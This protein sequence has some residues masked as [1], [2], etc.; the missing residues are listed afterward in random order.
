MKKLLSTLTVIALFAATA[1]TF[2]QP[3]RRPDEKPGFQPQGGP[4]QPGVKPGAAQPSFKPGPTQPAPK[5]GPTQPTPKPGPAQPGF[6][7]VP[8][9][10]TPTAPHHGPDAPHRPGQSHV[11]QQPVPQAPKPVQPA[12]KP[13]Q[14][15]PAPGVHPQPGPGAPGYRPGFKHHAL[16][17]P[18]EHGYYRD[19][20]RPTHKQYF[21]YL[22]VPD[23]MQLHLYT[24]QE[25]EIKLEEERKEGFFWF[26]RYDASYVD[27]D[28]DHEKGHRN[29]FGH[30]DRYAEIEIKALRPGVS[31]VE[32]IYANRRGWDNGDAPVK[33]IQ[34][35]VFTE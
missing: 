26:A 23:K 19:W 29:F 8:A 7:P 5:P 1:T 17:R 16:P 30:R 14:P 25:F 27:I 20:M 11:H 2:A 34:V 9:Q 4:P 18:F 24:G 21:E 28:I 15:A 13:A 32:L 31:M 35:F 3:G 22:T 33:V 10:P 12:P 6:K